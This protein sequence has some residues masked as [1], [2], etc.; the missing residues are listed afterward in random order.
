MREKK[1]HLYVDNRERTILLAYKSTRMA[2]IGLQGKCL[3]LF[4]K[5]DAIYVNGEMEVY[6]YHKEKCDFIKK[7]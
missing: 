3:T 2:K 6:E 7:Y 1:T 4:D 5:S